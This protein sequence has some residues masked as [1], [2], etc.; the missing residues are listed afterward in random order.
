MDKI[1]HY[2]VNKDSQKE[3]LYMYCKH[4]G[5]QI[6]GLQTFLS[7]P[8]LVSRCTQVRELIIDDGMEYGRCK[9]ESD[10]LW[11]ED[12]SFVLR[13]SKTKYRHKRQLFYR[14]GG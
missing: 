10:H 13:L 12:I 6:Q 2:S 14:S 1:F 4:K 5:L 8:L 7:S 9:Q 11:M 3:L